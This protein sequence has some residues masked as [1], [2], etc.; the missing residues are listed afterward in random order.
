MAN[1]EAKATVIVDMDKAVTGVK[2]LT[3]EFLEAKQK[4]DNLAGS[5]D[6]THFA[7][8]GVAAVKAATVTAAAFIK[9][10]IDSAD[11]LAKQSRALGMSGIELQELQRAADLSGIS[12]EQLTTAMRTMIVGLGQAAQGTGTAKDLLE[13]L[14]VS[15][16]DLS[17]MSGAEKIAFLTEKINETVPASQRAAAMA[18]LF[19]SHSALAMQ[20]LDPDS[21]KR[22]AEEVNKFG[23]ALSE[24]QLAQIEEANNEMSVFGE[25]TKGIQNQLA[26]EFAPII[27][28][29]SKEIA[30]AAKESGLFDGAIQKAVDIGINGAGLLADAWRGFEYIL[31]GL[32]GV[33]YG[34]QVAAA[35]VVEAIMQAFQDLETIEVDIIN[36]LISAANNIPGVNIDLIHVEPSEALQA[37]T[38]F[39]NE[40][41]IELAT[42]A[43]EIRSLMDEPLPSEKLDALIANWRAVSE[44][45]AEATVVQR[46]A[47]N[48]ALPQGREIAEKKEKEKE[49]PYIENLK[50]QTN[51]LVEELNKREQFSLESTLR[52]NENN[53]TKQFEAIE[54]Q[55]EL[56]TIAFDEKSAR[57][58]EAYSNNLINEEAYLAA[59]DQLKQNYEGL[60][61]Q[62]IEQQESIKKE[63]YAKTYNAMRGILADAAKESK[64]AFE[65]N[66]AVS[67]AETVISTYQAAQSSYSAMAGIPYVGPALGAAAAAAA[68]ASGM[69][70]VNA[71]KSQQFKGGGSAGGDPGA[72]AL[73]A[74][75]P[76]AAGAQPERQVANI[77]L[78]GDM[79]GRNQVI[80]LMESMNELMADGVRLNVK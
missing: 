44:A 72:S 61:K 37:V 58:N 66:K 30:D 50:K 69:M 33:W 65:L 24:I 42:V 49:D 38:N 45:A 68:I 29:V 11:A 21:L 73:A 25:M 54:K 23:I 32:K 35:S 55:K 18:D 5:L 14:G 12:T 71:I 75:A 53:F 40:A 22:A 8:W 63:A 2:K 60:E 74:S 36:S 57:L 43:D 59:Q 41:N 10:S 20:N 4:A 17:D 70:R 76:V 15:L 31:L 78:V 28:G 67:I 46:E 64:K 79:F 9:M 27:T 39:K 6:T 80:G 13:Q 3:K 62:R 48:A 1:K 77:S 34:I 7:K 19:G 26:V 47:M 56:D 52:E 16:N 51:A